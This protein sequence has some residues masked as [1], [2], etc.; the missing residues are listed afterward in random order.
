MLQEEITVAYCKDIPSL[1]LLYQA[2]ADK[3]ALLLKLIPMLT[4]KSEVIGHHSSHIKEL[5]EKLKHAF[6]LQSDEELLSNLSLSITHLLQTEHA[7]LK[8]EA[9]VIV[10]ELVQEVIDKIDRLLEADIKLYDVLATSGD[11]TPK[12]RSKK[13][14]GRK[15]KS[16]KTKVISDV[17]YGLRI[18]LCRLKC[19]VRYLNIR[20]YLPPELGLSGMSADDH[21]GLEGRMDKLIVAVGDLLGRRTKAVSDLDEGFRHVDTIKHSLTII[22]S[23]LLWTTAPIFKSI[24][25]NR[26][27]DSSLSVDDGIAETEDDP[28]LQGW[29]QQVCRSRSTLEEALIC[30]LEMHLTRTKNAAHEE[31]KGNEESP[32]AESVESMEE[33][34]F[35]DESIAT[36]VKEAQRFA[37]LTFCDVRCLF[38]EKFQDAT[39]PYDALEWAL[40]K[41]LVLLTQMHFERE[42]D[43][44]EE[45]EPEFE[46]DMVENDPAVAKEKADAI[47]QWEE[48]QQRKA[49]L[50]VAL[51]RVSLC[52]PSKKHQAAAVLQ[53]FTSSGKPSVEVV[54][55]FSKQVK[56]DAPVRY[57]E[58]QMTALR[59]MF[60]S[61]LIWKQDLEAAASGEG[62]DDENSEQEELKE[63]MESSEHELRELARR[64]SQS[65]GVGKIPSSLRAPFLRF[66]REGV[67]YSMEQPHQFEFLETMRAYVS[68]LD[69]SSMT[70]LHEYF[71]ERLQSRKDVPNKSDDVGPQWKAV[72]DFQSSI[73]AASVGNARKRVFSDAML[74]PPL[75]SKRR[76]ASSE[77]TPM[78]STSIAEEGEDEVAKSEH[79]AI[80]K[81]TDDTSERNKDEDGG[82]GNTHVDH[83]NRHGS[84]ARKR[85]AE[86]DENADSADPLTHRKRSRPSRNSEEAE[87][88]DGNEVLESIPAKRSSVRQHQEEAN[89]QG[90]AQG[91]SSQADQQLQEEANS[92]E[93]E[94]VNTRNRRKRRRA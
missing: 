51:G 34:E 22:Y 69:T 49:E 4:L 50:L 64:F 57:L 23:D 61:I 35:E 31:Q 78:Q 30:V 52:N 7:S 63:K 20:E 21:T 73:S 72:F 86:V 54:K 37:F 93:D 53:Y 71:M 76:S 11:D 25:K 75:K 1:F 90:S 15:K 10:R 16:A 59:Q 8:R 66:L 46:D 36:Y 65:L 41:V 26:K 47:R 33:I 17:E 91:A 13:S 19:L 56:T 39:A 68:H 81:T 18:A 29:I 40:P 27:R 92:Q 77:P 44:A 70:Q 38:V 67:R 9:E 42:M 58:I 60:N 6:L 12:P 43:D 3:L 85:A 62:N 5:L 32:D 94:G 89:S 87:S 80:L 24:G 55:A 28:S 48:K 88:S 2:D 14:K 84:S 82:Q 83:N 74:S 45:E 79:S